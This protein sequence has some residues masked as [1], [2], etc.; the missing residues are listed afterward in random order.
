[1]ALQT[2]PVFYLPSRCHVRWVIK[3][4]WFVGNSRKFAQNLKWFSDFE[5][6]FSVR[7]PTVYLIL[8]FLISELVIIWVHSS[9]KSLHPVNILQPRSDC[10][11]LQIDRFP[12]WSVNFCVLM[13]PLT[14]T[15]DNHLCDIMFNRLLGI[16]SILCIFSCTIFIF[17]TN[18]I[19]DAG[20]CNNVKL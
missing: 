7:R 5:I 3:T 1:M 6:F 15:R 11:V 13:V 18:S 2:T 17:F 4:W 9:Q 10:R 12:F 14:N 8:I 19:K 20:L 16:S